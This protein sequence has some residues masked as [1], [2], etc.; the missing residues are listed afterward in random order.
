MSTRWTRS[1]TMATWTGPSASPNTADWPRSRPPTTQTT[2]STATPTSSQPAGRSEHRSGRH[3]SNPRVAVAGFSDG[4]LVSA[5]IY[6]TQQLLGHA[7]VSTTANIYVQGSPA[8]LEEK[9]ARSRANGRGQRF[10][11]TPY[12]RNRSHRLWLC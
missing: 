6:A 2:S 10:R 11:S 9:P 5:D 1:R 8:D 4:V 7:D 12:R 3:R